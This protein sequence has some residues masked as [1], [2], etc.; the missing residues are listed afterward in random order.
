MA[1]ANG[2]KLHL[3]TNAALKGINKSV[4]E[5]FGSSPAWYREFQRKRALLDFAQEKGISFNVYKDDK[6]AKELVLAAASRYIALN[7]PLAEQYEKGC[8]KSYGR[9]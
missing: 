6:G 8:G 1:Y 4:E 7:A 3:L 2:Q 5:K 9:A